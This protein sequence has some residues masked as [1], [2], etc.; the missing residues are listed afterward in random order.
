MN[1]TKTH[2]KT[3][4]QKKGSAFV[5]RS[6]NPKHLE[7]DL[8]VF[9]SGWSLTDVQMQ[10]IAAATDPECHIEAPGGCCH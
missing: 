5:T 7:E 4:T 1:A 10:A 3:N 2:N 8:E 6:D 9:S